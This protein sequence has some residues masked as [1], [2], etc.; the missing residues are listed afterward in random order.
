MGDETKAIFLKSLDCIQDPTERKRVPSAF[1][2]MIGTKNGSEAVESAPTQEEEQSNKILNN[3]LLQDWVDEIPI[4]VMSSTHVNP[5]ACGPWRIG[6]ESR[7][8]FP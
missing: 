5:Q 3:N 8:I 4:D 2:K 7:L 6:P 1:K